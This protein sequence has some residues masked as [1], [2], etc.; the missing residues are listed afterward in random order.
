MDL[1]TFNKFSGST[2]LCLSISHS[3]LI[4]IKTF[5]D[6]YLFGKNNIIQFKLTT[7]IFKERTEVV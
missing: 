5:I 4:Q 2:I 1:N 6:S 3:H 7:I